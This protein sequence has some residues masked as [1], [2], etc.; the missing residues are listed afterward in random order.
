MLQVVDYFDVDLVVEAAVALEDRMIKV[1]KEPS[2]AVVVAVAKDTLAVLVD[3]RVMPT[4]A[5]VQAVLEI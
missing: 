5:K 1:V 4:M 3:L 2:E